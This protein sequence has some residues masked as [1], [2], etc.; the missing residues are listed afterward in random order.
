MMDTRGTETMPSA[1]IQ[2]MI[3]PATR[4]R[5]ASRPMKKPGTSCRKMSGMLNE[6]QRARN[7]IALSQPSAS[8]AP[9][10]WIGW[11]ATKPT[12]CPP[13]R[14]RAVIRLRPKRSFTWKISPP[15][16]S[17]RSTRVMS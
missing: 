1:S 8:Q 10:F 7:E 13:M 16:A 3:L 2:V 15:S 4:L 14:A 11:L 5:S 12:T 17:R 6:S 9:P